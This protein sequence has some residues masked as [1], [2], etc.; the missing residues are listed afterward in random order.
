MRVKREIQLISEWHELGRKV[1][2]ERANWS[3]SIV[4]SGIMRALY[5]VMGILSIIVASMLYPEIK[6]DFQK[7]ITTCGVFLAGLFFMVGGLFPGEKGG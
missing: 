3:W 1:K 6:D 2:K 4:R 5:F 7:C